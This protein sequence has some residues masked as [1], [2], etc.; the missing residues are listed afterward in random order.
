MLI[1][2]N[3][4]F[5]NHTSTFLFCLYWFTFTNSINPGNDGNLFDGLHNF[6][7]AAAITQ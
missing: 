3:A 5:K 4:G 6:V 2:S 7:P 1:C